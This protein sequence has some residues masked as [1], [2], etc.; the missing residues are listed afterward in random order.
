ML[1]IGFIPFTFKS[2]LAKGKSSERSAI[3]ELPSA[4]VLISKIVR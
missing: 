4:F 2:N 1:S 3:S